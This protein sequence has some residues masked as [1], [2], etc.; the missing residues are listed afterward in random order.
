MQSQSEQ[1]L[2]RI[3]E[4]VTLTS[5]GQVTL[6]QNVGSVEDLIVTCLV[7]QNVAHRAGKSPKDTMSV[8]DFIAAGGLAH[9]AAR[10]SVYN[11]TSQLVKRKIIQKRGSEFLVGERTVLQYFA[12]KVP[13]LTAQS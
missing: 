9:T 10:Q 5:D 12:A 1:W 8:D 3:Q 6:L 4:I 7:V 11:C 2:E 13:Q